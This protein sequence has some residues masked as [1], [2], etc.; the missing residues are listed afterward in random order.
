MNWYLLVTLTDDEANTSREWDREF[1]RQYSFPCGHYDFSA[2]IDPIPVEDKG[3]KV[4]LNFVRRPMVYFMR[5]ELIDVLSPELEQHLTLGR[6]TDSSG[7]VI[8]DVRTLY[9]KNLVQLRGGPKSWSWICPACHQLIYS[10]HWDEKPYLLASELPIGPIAMGE[11]PEIIVNDELR[12]RLAGRKWKKLRIVALP[13]RDAPIDG[14]PLDLWQLTPEQE[15]VMG[16]MPRRPISPQVNS[17]DR[18]SA[19]DSA[20]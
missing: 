19:N 9:S 2:W 10:V 16:Q 11:G 7:H 1:R 8:D 14:F 15:R 5:Q 6:L 17:V 18:P 20:T 4:P 12:E 13:V 3:E